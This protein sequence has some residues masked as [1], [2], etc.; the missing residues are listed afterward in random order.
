MDR[1]PFAPLRRPRPTFLKLDLGEPCCPAKRANHT[2]E[3]ANIFEEH[4]RP[5]TSGNVR[6]I[7]REGWSVPLSSCCRSDCKGKL[8]DVAEER[9]WIDAR[10][11][12]HRQSKASHMDEKSAIR[13]YVP[14]VPT[15]S[16]CAR[17]FR[18][19][20][21]GTVLASGRFLPGSRLCGTNPPHHGSSSPIK[22]LDQKR[23][24]PVLTT[25]P[26]NRGWSSLDVRA[27]RC[28]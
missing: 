6:G 3:C 24:V 25:F 11:C 13:T 1:H 23:D 7:T 5:V 17:L 10:Q 4:R 12:T 28:R 27:R 20:A 2:T 14:P 21:E 26:Y 19:S 16:S 9:A 22:T 8:G 18:K 15:P